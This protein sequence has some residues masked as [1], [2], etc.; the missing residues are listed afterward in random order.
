MLS[1]LNYVTQRQS[2]ESKLLEVKQTR[3]EHTTMYV[4][5][6]GIEAFGSEANSCW[7]YRNVCNEVYMND[8]QVNT[9]ARFWNLGSVSANIRI[10]RNTLSVLQFVGWA[11]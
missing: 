7:T 3:V 11:V 2:G 8:V 5:K 6:W 4:M 1:I 9:H 10:D